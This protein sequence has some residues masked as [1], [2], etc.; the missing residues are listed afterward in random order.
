[1]K[2]GDDDLDKLRPLNMY[3]YSKHLFDVH[4]K[5]HDWLSR[6]VGLKY[7]NVF[8]PNEGHKGEMRSVVHKAYGQIRDTGRV[9]LFKS[10]HPDYRD[11]EQKR[12][13]FYVKDAVDATLHLAFNSKAAGL[14]NLGSGRAS[15]WI[16]LV[17]PI[18]EE[19]GLKV[20][21]E[22]IDLPESLREKYQ[23]YTCADISRLRATGWPG[24]AFALERAVRDYVSGYLIPGLA[25]QPD[26][27]EVLA[28]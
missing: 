20:D 9:K 6:I 16:E 15:T 21:I 19:L 14:F 25:L 24:P 23:Y 22:F 1:M 2:D 17:T 12:D 8:G 3:G 11:G 13:F 7:F 26:P 5:R 18:F 10:A 27:R 4:A 28:Q